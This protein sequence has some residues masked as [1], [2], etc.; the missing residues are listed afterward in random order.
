MQWCIEY[1]NTECIEQLL[2]HGA[3]P[4]QEGKATLIEM[5]RDGVRDA[6]CARMKK[7]SKTTRPVHMAAL[8]GRQDVIELLIGYDAP[9]D[10]EEDTVSGKR[11]RIHRAIS[12]NLNC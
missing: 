9:V 7:G 11:F 5:A 1:V 3:D 6:L 4:L 2:R 10:Y 12:Q 8:E